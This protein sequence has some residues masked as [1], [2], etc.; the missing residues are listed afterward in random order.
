MQTFQKFFGIIL[1]S[2]ALF[3]ACQENVSDPGINN[4]DQTLSKIVHHVSV[5]GCDI[6]PP[7]VDR[8]FSL[9]ANMN[10][11]GEVSGQ[12]QD[13]FGGGQG[14]IHVAVD[15]LEIVG[16]GNEA[17]IG[18]VITHGTLNGVDVSGQ[19]AVTKVV[20]NGQGS[21]ADPDQI[22]YSY[23]STTIG[24]CDDYLTANFP[25]FDIQCGQVKVK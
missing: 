13:G 6:F 12:W 3:S 10:H 23:F 25:L 11:N 5:G 2:F 1:L 16:S 21:N 18:G 4:S 15:C 14:S 20:D 19:R 7:G 9:V 24:S 17:I 8:N 22:S